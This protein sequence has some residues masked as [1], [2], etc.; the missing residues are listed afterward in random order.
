MHV[1]FLRDTERAFP[2]RPDAGRVTAL[3]VWHCAYP[4]L[5]SLPAYSAVET[6]VV[7]SYPDADLRPVAQLA[8]LQY[9]EI[10]HLPNVSDLA[11]LAELRGLTT[12][13][14]ATLPSWDAGGKK[15]VVDSLA[16]LAALPDLRH[17][18]LFGV[19][20]KDGSLR[21]LERSTSL[22]TVRVST[23]DDAEQAR[24]YRATGW[25]DEFAPGPGVED[26]T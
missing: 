10:V 9:L 23:Y 11:P 13:R 17:L 18:E 21:E 7:A 3:R 14:L 8:R 25:S 22:R 24:F 16:P 1:T 15:T 2:V 4:S 20:S 12:V 19:V 26:W 6:L 5:A